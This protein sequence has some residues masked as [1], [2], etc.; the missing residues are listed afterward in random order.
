MV[1]LTGNQIVKARLLALQSAMDLE[2][3][4]LRMTKGRSA[5]S[6]VKAEFG[7]A[8]NRAK[9]QTQ[10]QVVIDSMSDSP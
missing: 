7:F 5:M 9:I 10:L 1:V 3:R 4:G 2:A 8:G 6:V